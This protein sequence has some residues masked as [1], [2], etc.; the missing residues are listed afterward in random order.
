MLAE[1]SE[2][3]LDE[4]ELVV[5]AWQDG[6]KTLQQLGNVEN[7]CLNGAGIILDHPL[8]VGVVVTI[9]CGKGELTAVVRQC[10]PLADGQFMGVELLRTDPLGAAISESI[11]RR[12]EGPKI[13]AAT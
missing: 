9:T 1:R 7:V 2:V 10:A 3:L 13:S 8:A 6:G 4:V 5:I 12:R 11:A